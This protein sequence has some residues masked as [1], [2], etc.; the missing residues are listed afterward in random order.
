M[1]AFFALTSAAPFGAFASD[2]E[3]FS[4]CGKLASPAGE[5]CIYSNPFTAGSDVLYYFT[6]RAS[7]ARDWFDEA[8]DVRKAWENM[9]AKTP[10]VITVVLGSWWLMLDQ[11]K[12]GSAGPFP[13]FVNQLM[14]WLEAKAGGVHGRRLLVGSSM[15]GFNASQLLLRIPQTFDKIALLCPAIMTISPYAKIGESFEYMKESGAEAFSTWLLQFFFRNSLV[16]EAEWDQV[17]PM[18]VGQKN[19][20]ADTPPLFVSAGE[21]D[22]Y[23]FHYGA[24]K[25]AAMA[26]QLSHSPVTWRSVPGNHCSFDSG[27]LAEFLV[28]R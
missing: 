25:F 15:G 2:A 14:P 20:G 16:N 19:L 5:Y 1:A 8:K 18:L 9:G 17:S 22:H 3:W 26:A 13:A 7:T 6:G 10:T 21:Q 24:E 12:D 23:G 28:D 11:N 4:D 27:G